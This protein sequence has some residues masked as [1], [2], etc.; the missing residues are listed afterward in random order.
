MNKENKA[1]AIDPK[2]INLLEY[3]YEPGQ[4]VEVPGMLLYALMQ[5]LREVK[6]QETNTA[7]THYYSTG[8]KLQ[9]SEDGRL[10]KVVEDKVLYPTAEAFFAQEPTLVT[11]LLG[12]YSQDML[13]QVQQAHLLNIETGLAKQVGTFETQSDVKL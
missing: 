3:V 11:S 7:F 10:E 5:V 1:E 12:V 6:E 9:N 8:A 13:L 4:M 2:G